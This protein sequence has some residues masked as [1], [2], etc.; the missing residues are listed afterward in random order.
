[1]TKGKIIVIEGTDCSG[2]EIQSKKLVERLSEEGCKTFYYNY[3][4]YASPTGKIIGLPYLGKSY[5]GAELVNSHREKVVERLKEIYQKTNKTYDEKIVDLAIDLM[6]EEL[7]VGWFKEGALNVDPKIAGAYYTIDRAYNA[8]NVDKLLDEGNV[9][10]DRYYYSNMGHQ[11]GKIKSSKERK[12]YYE[13]NVRLERE[14]FGLP[15][16]DIAIF[17]HVP[18]A[19]T[20]ILK[21]ARGEELDE[22]EKDT[23]HLKNAEKAYLELATNYGFETI[24]CLHEKSVPIKLSDV[25][26]IDEIHEEVYNVVKRKL[27][28]R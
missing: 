15:K 6:G 9:V 24:D 8:P 7:G 3:P 27:N 20:A 23:E 26:T 14:M 25:K 19:Y 10:I 5:L 11:G 21:K 28:L 4:N 22:H 13:W 12:D 2:K 16:E 1:M 18:T 17:L